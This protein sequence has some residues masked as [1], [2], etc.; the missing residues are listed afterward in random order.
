MPGELESVDL[1]SFQR[2]KFPGSALPCEQAMLN[3]EW[4]LR[5]TAESVLRH[6]WLNGESLDALLEPPDVIAE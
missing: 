3:P 4:R 2:G 6:P 5:P 1:E